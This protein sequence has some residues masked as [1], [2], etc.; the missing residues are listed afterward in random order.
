MQGAEEGT[1]SK[2]QCLRELVAR[3]IHDLVACSGG[4]KARLGLDGP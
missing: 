1:A 3:R 2:A 4:V